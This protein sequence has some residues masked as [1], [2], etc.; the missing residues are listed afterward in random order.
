MSK[1][2]IKDTVWFIDCFDNLGSGVII[3]AVTK[4]FSGE[5]ITIYTIKGDI[6]EVNI[7]E[8]DVFLTEKDASLE[9]ISRSKRKVKEY[10]KGIKS[11]RDLLSFMLANLYYE[12]CDY[13]VI[14]ASKEKIKEIVG[15]ELE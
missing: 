9:K 14:T 1:A 6:G 4:D 5:T 10:K 11:L 8:D 12:D 2:N 15:I 7:L 13:E 3:K